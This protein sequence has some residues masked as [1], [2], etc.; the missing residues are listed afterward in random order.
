MKFL[1]LHLLNIKCD[2]GQ[3]NQSYISKLSCIII[4]TWINKLSINVWFVM[5][6]QYL[7]EIQLWTLNIWNLRVQKN[8]NIFE[9]IA[10]KVV[11]R[12]FLAMHMTCKFW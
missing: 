8:E 5:I 3:Q 10:F 7:A 9:K 6:E 11:Q 4:Y 12:K 1:I 2:L